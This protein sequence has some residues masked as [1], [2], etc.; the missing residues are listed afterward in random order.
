[1]TWG[2]LSVLVFV[3]KGRYDEFVVRSTGKRIIPYTLY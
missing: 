2:L 3:L 1:M